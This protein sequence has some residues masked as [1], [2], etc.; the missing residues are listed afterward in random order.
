MTAVLR[1]R[2]CAE[3]KRPYPETDKFFNRHIRG[4]GGWYYICKKCKCAKEKQRR[5]I[6]PNMDRTNRFRLKYGITYEHYLLMLEQA[7]HKCA[8]CNKEETEIQQP[9]KKVKMLSVDHDHATGEVRG[10]LCGRCNKAVGLFSDDVKLLDSAIKYLTMGKGER[11][12]D[13]NFK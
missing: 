8:I 1:F 3:C 12:N 11:Y 4:K 5:K 9:S 13:R 10:L 2:K 7:G 6:N